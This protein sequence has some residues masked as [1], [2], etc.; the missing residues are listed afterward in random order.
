MGSAAG[1]KRGGE[2]ISTGS[3]VTWDDSM[4]GSGEGTSTAAADSSAAI[5]GSKGRRNKVLD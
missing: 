3:A 2:L 5:C 4:A 1:T